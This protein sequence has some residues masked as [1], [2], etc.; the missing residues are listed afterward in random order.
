MPSCLAETI[1]ASRLQVAEQLYEG[2]NKTRAVSVGAL[3]RGIAGHAVRDLVKQHRRADAGRGD[4]DGQPV[5]ICRR[6][7]SR[8]RQLPDLRR[9]CQPGP[10]PH[11]I[12]DC[13]ALVEW[14]GAGVP[15]M[16]VL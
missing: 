5:R 7:P 3:A 16:N 8:A 13:L 2:A 10:R 6:A 4:A 14:D 12:D 9:V 11:V 1:S 15:G